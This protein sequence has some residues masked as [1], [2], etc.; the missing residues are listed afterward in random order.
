[1]RAQKSEKK[2]RK[3]IKFKFSRNLENRRNWAFQIDSL[4]KKVIIS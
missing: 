3:K 2:N 4:H 1:M